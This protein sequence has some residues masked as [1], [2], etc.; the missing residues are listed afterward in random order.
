MRKSGILDLSPVGGQMKNL[1]R[2][3]AF[4]D[5]LLK[6][7]KDSRATFEDAE[8]IC[9]KTREVW[10]AVLPALLDLDVSYDALLAD[11]AT[12]LEKA[13]SEVMRTLQSEENKKVANILKH[14]RQNICRRAQLVQAFRM[15]DTKQLFLTLKEIISEDRNVD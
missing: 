10:L 4:I 7:L 14:Y 2:L 5:E 6:L 12:G 9:M 8:A 1:E 3:E 13:Q 11:L 15:E